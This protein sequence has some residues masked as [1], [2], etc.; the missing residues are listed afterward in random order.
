[1][2]STSVAA[3]TW[4]SAKSS[5]TREYVLTL[6]FEKHSTLCNNNGHISVY[7]ALAVIVGQGYCHIRILDAD[8]EWDSENAAGCFFCD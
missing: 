7:E 1:M 2:P 8:I 3:Q 4:V 5:G 6:F